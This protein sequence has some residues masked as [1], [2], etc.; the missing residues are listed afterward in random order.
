MTGSQSWVLKILQG[1]TNRYIIPVY[2]RK[3]DWKE[4]Q[5]KQLYDDLE[6]VISQGRSN[7]FFGSVVVVSDESGTMGEYLIVDGQQRITTII[8]LLLA[9][10]RLLDSGTITSHDM[11]LSAKIWR[12]YLTDEF[13]Q[14]DGQIKL[15]PIEKDQKAL[16][17]LFFSP[18]DEWPTG[19]NLVDTYR[20][21][22]KR[23]QTGTLSA[24]QLFSAISLLTIVNISLNQE[25]N[26]QLVFESLNSK[27]LPLDEG[28]KIRN[29][30]LMG[31]PA[32]Q[33]TACYKKY[34]MKLE[35]WVQP[36]LSGFF[37]DYLSVK[38][39]N[40][41]NIKAVYTAF[42]DYQETNDTQDIEI[43]L[44]ELCDYAKLYK[45]L[46]HGTD[47]PTDKAFNACIYR[48][49]RLE[50]TVTR[51]FFLELLRLCEAGII[52]KSERDEILKITE[53]YIFRR[54]ICDLPT[55]SL[56]KIF[57]LLHREIMRIDKTDTNYLE[58]FKFALL[59]KRDSARYP[60]DAEF[61]RNLSVRNIYQM[62]SKNKK[63]LFE[64]LENGGTIETKE[65][66]L[67]LDDETYSIEHI[68][69]QHLTNS[70][71]TSL[72]DDYEA[73]HE[74]WIHRLANLTLTAYNGS[75]SNHSFAEKRDA[76]NGYRSSGLRLNQWIAD[77]GQW[78]LSELEERDLALQEKALILWPKPTTSYHPPV[79]PQD[80]IALEDDVDLTGRE[81]TRFRFRT[82]E[83]PVDSWVE[84]YQQVLLAL[85]SENSAI[86]TNLAL[87]NDQSQPLT[88]HFSTSPD[89]YHSCREL[90]Q[91]LYVW[92]GTQTQYKLSV[93]RKL[94]SL[95]E[96][97]EG[98]LI[99]YLKEVSESGSPVTSTT[100]RKDYWTL[101]LPQIREALQGAAFVN[102]N[103]TTSNYIDGFIGIQGIHLCCVAN[104]DEA[105]VELYLGGAEKE[106]NKKLFDYLYAHKAEIE[107]AT[108]RTYNWLRQEDNKAS[109]ISLILN[110]I[111]LTDESSWASI[112]C[113]HAEE[114]QLLYSAARPWI[115]QCPMA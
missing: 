86:L 25:D 27:G 1:S 91:A 15:K 57:L 114:M 68:M 104:F 3:Y 41:P 60:D 51:P 39:Q 81:I 30:I 74:T 80:V 23:I 11:Q 35:E 112:A 31:L 38:Q 100:L 103:P 83:Q 110:D 46:L 108:G 85:H 9:L 98:D 72:G 6:K 69:P 99:F 49:N 34:W 12:Q 107:S 75:Y 59:S 20:Y 65:I 71:I 42:K 16:S 53:Q 18:E 2:Q 62:N 88:L 58:K 7:H 63:Y 111:S 109:R 70:W 19:S 113:F 28:D 29:Y 94:F 44:Q 5:C 10:C 78:T 92:T 66:W 48:L 37:R 95:F 90:N 17:A 21:F 14:G 36:E 79:K 40:T 87:S 73:I 97:D 13:E 96:V 105:R 22:Y 77:R 8:L 4:P 101:A 56:N 33:Q 52:T 84:M 24:D 106:S 43:L 61:T 47:S 102:V 67:H 115:E 45:M 54:T 89:A 82:M 26:P 55:N 50:T 32:K 76:L 93:L 64:R